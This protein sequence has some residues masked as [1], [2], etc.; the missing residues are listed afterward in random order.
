MVKLTK[1]KYINLD[2]TRYMAKMPAVLAKMPSLI[3]VD[4]KDHP[5]WSAATKVAATKLL[6]GVNVVHEVKGETE[7]EIVIPVQTK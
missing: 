2:G 1:L 6:P 7:V 5:E 3:R 4:V